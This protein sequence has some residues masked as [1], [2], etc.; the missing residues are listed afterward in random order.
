VH[1]QFLGAVLDVS[2][3]HWF[4]VPFRGIAITTGCFAIGAGLVLLR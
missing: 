4:A 3:H 1:D 2:H